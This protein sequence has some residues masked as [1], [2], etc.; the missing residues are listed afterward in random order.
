MLAVVDALRQSVD[1]QLVT[2]DVA[3]LV[4]KRDKHQVHRTRRLKLGD[5]VGQHLL[6]VRVAVMDGAGNG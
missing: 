3:Q 5:V 2:G 1:L 6:G 4:A